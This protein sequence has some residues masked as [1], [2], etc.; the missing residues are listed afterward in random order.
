MVMAKNIPGFLTAS[1]NSRAAS[2]T[3][4]PDAMYGPVWAAPLWRDGR[5]RT[6][7]VAPATNCFVGDH[8]ATFEQQLLDIA[9]AQAEPE[10]PANRAADDD[11]RG[12]V[13]VIKRFRFL[14]RLILPPPARQ[15]DRA[16][17]TV[18]VVLQTALP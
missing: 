15:P 5:I 14:H 10:R 7:F 17:R 13:A 9:Q 18:W 16:R 3:S 11:G 1:L 2:R 8:D 6:E 4:R 12:A